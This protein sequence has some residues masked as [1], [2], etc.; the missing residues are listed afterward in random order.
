MALTPLRASDPP[1]YG[2][3]ELHGR[4]GAGGMGVVYLAFG[5]DSESPAG[6][7]K[8]AAA[9]AGDAPDADKPGPER[10][11]VALKVLQPGLAHDD[12]YRQRFIR[13]VRAAASVTSPHVARVVASETE[14]AP[15]WMATE[16]IEGA[17]LAHAVETNGPIPEARLTGLAADLATALGALHDAGL[18]H[19][20]MKPQNVVLAWS[21]PKLI[22]FGIAKHEGSSELTQAGMAVGSP[23]WM[24]PEVLAGSEAA[25]ASDIFG[26]GMCVA[27]AG[28]GRAPFGSG[29]P[30]S[31]AARIAGSEPDLDGLPGSIAGLVGDALSKDTARRPTAE[32]LTAALGHPGSRSTVVV[33]PREEGGWTG[34]REPDTRLATQP[35]SAPSGLPPNPPSNPPSGRPE[36]GSAT[37]VAKEPNHRRF[38]IVLG[39]LAALL[40]AAGVIVG[41]LVTRDDKNGT[42]GGGTPVAPA[43]G[44]ITASPTLASLSQAEAV[45]MDDGYT[46]TSIPRRRLGSARRRSTSSCVQG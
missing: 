35:V 12:E 10:A 44:T 19:R 34:P 37:T 14:S 25:K 26:W 20:D 43:S 16:Y 18:V 39:S 8:G 6:D 3:Y 24:S 29:H 46:P 23:L 9:G 32:A 40:I 1:S 28:T 42:G 4:L 30:S 2:P 38:A 17:T 22:D 11:A 41:I 33:L 15:L 7:A 31:V 5:P 36:P 27:F 21:G 45:V 13:E